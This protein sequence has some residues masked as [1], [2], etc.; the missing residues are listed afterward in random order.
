MAETDQA[1]S[2][3]EATAKQVPGSAGAFLLAAE[4]ALATAGASET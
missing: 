4:Q 3:F 2:D 1:L